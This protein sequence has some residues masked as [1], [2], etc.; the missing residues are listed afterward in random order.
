MRC[1]ALQGLGRADDYEQAI[2][3]LESMCDQ[4]LNGE[5]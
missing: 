3:D 2:Q 4:F 5:K 1:R